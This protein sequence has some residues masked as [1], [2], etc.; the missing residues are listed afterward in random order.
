[1]KRT[2]R[3]YLGLLLA[4]LLAF[5]GQSMAVARGMPMAAGEVVLCTGQGP[6]TVE[7]DENGQPTGKTHICPDCAL[8]LFAYAADR[9]VQPPR[10]SGRAEALRLPERPL[11]ASAP[12]LD[13]AARGP[14]RR[15]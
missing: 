4:V 12:A 2:L 3:T 9:P 7:V 5:T 13:P 11:A 10:P 6:V 15:A 14:P 1:M 8:S